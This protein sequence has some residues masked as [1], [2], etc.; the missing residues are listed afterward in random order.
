MP[1]TAPQL[2]VASDPSRFK[3]LITGRRFGKTFL[4]IRELCRA[5]AKKPSSINWVITPSYRMGKQIWWAT[6]KKKL[7]DLRW[8]DSSNEAELIIFLKNGS[9]IAV[10]GAD[11]PDSLR[12]LGLDMVIFDEFQSTPRE[13]WTEVI[14]PALSDKQGNAL[15]CGTPKGVGSFSHDLFTRA[16]NEQDWNAWQFTTLQGG[17]VP[18]EEI[19]AARRDLDER[20]FRAE[21]EATFT[22]FGGVVAYNFDYKT[23]V[24]KLADP[25][26]SVLH[27]GIDFNILPMTAAIAQV[28]GPH[29]HVFDEIK[30]E[31]S[32]TEELCFELR[33]RYPYARIVVYPDPASRQKR[34][35]A[36]GKTDFSILMNAGFSVKSRT[37]HTPVRDRVN[38]LNARLRNAAGEVNLLVDPKCR[39]VIDSLQ[40]LTYKE[41]TSVIDKESG[42]DHMFDALSYMTD[43]LY[44]IKTNYE[45]PEEPQRWGVQIK[46]R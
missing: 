29:L 28:R 22:T 7:S 10:K 31:G 12:G 3:V 13:A 37:F 30:L 34:T 6:L 24:I 40:R 11:S 26:T 8:I 19:E 41:G 1:L 16:L 46:R 39:N 9:Q 17:N 23:H 15:F 4:G 36:G 2:E 38:G 18:A 5:A 33:Q 27:V 21:Y 25:E 42:F 20:T 44:P 45:I 32:N 14:R 35:S 43:Y